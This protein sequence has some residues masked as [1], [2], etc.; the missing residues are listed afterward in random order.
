MTRRAAATRQPEASS[1]SE[2]TSLARWPSQASRLA[3][4]R[5]LGASGSRS[6]RRASRAAPRSAAPR[7]PPQPRRAIG[8]FSANPRRGSA[9]APSVRPPRSLSLSRARQPLPVARPARLPSRAGAAAGR[10]ALRSLSLA[11]CTRAHTSRLQLSG[12]LRSAG[13]SRPPSQPASRAAPTHAGLAPQVRRGAMQLVSYTRVGGWAWYEGVCVGL[14]ARER[15]LSLGRAAPTPRGAAR[16]TP[17]AHGLARPA[18]KD[19][20][21]RTARVACREREGESSALAGLSQSRERTTPHGDLRFGEEQSS[22]LF[23]V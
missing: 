10:W 8:R 15:A 18:W 7:K 19:A 9:R 2:A 3:F 14:V 16:G 12:G 5:D 22:R 21:A 6:A 11:R 1:D 17:L 23:A 13:S 4:T 20:T